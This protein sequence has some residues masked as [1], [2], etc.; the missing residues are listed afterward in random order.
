MIILQM[1]L[2]TILSILTGRWDSAK[3][4]D[5][6]SLETNLLIRTNPNPRCLEMTERLMLLELAVLIFE[7]LEKDILY[8]MAISYT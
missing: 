5:K 8:S 7:N 1:Q 4:H 6:L 3:Q 2:F